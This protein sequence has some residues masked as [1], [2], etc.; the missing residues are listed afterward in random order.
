MEHE[1]EIWGLKAKPETV[2][3]VPSLGSLDT[4]FSADGRYGGL[5]NFGFSS[6]AET[7]S[8]AG[9]SRL[10]Y[11]RKNILEPYFSND[12]EMQRLYLASGRG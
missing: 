9:G 8:P 5:K 11:I 4:R 12:P 10:D 1:V 2:G 7:P 6:L 3:Q